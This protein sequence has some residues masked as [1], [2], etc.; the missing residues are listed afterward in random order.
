MFLGTPSFQ[1]RN[2]FVP[3][4]AG[5]SRESVKLQVYARSAKD[6]SLA[7]DEIQKFIQNHITSKT[8]EHENLFDVVQKHWD[9]LKPLTKD[10][11]LR[12]RCVNA[13]TVSIAGMLNK[14]VEAKDKLTEL[15][16]SAASP[17]IFEAYHKTLYITIT[18]RILF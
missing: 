11:D 7:F 10:N 6:I 2:T 17:G 13:T 14:V 5:S 15:I 16:S 4:V 3:L 12:I 18:I 8:I 9:E 1:P